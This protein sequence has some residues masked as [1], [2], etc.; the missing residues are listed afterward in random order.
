MSISALGSGLSGML[1]NLRAI[2]STGHNIANANTN[3]FSPQ[4]VSFQE[5]AGGVSVNLSHTPTAGGESSGTDLAGEM[6]QSMIY[7]STFDASA[8]MVKTASDML[9]TLI[10]IQA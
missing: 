10:D 5:T 2:D 4:Q 7:Q 9:G 6:V 8:K 3:G 1:A